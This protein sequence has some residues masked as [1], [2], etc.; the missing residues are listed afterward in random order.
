MKAELS[1]FLVHIG[2]S[3]R[4]GIHI[5]WMRIARSVHVRVISIA[6]VGIHGRHRCR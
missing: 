3:I 5:G 6:R 4:L 1:R 2:V